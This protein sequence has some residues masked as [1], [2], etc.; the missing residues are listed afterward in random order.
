M[1]INWHRDKADVGKEA[2]SFV[3]TSV[4]KACTVR[5]TVKS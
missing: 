5:Y 4:L 1:N 3:R 2:V